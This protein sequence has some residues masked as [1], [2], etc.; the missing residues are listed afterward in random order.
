MD[1]VQEMT[2][3]DPPLSRTKVTVHYGHKETDIYWSTLGAA[4]F[5]R[6][7]IETQM[8]RVSNHRDTRSD[9][10]IPTTACDLVHVEALGFEDTSPEWLSDDPTLSGLT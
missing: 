3:G 6:Y 10:L 8:L 7:S 1:T 4:A 5:L 2:L 9:T